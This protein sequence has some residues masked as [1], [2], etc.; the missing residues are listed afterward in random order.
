MVACRVNERLG[1]HM[2]MDE[3]I[4][5][6]AEGDELVSNT[7]F[8]D[9]DLAYDVA[10]GATFDGV[11][12]RSCEF[13]GVDWSGSTF[14]DVVFRGCRFIR[15]NM[16][17]CWLNRC[18][19]VDCSAPG[20]NLLRARL[21]SVSFTLCDLSYANL[22]EGS[23][24][25]MAARDTRLTEAALQGAKLG[26]LRLDGCDLTRIDVFK[27][28]LSGVDVSCCIVRGSCRLGRTTMTLRGLTVNAEQALALS[29]LLGIQLADE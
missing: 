27:T 12:F 11:V 1:S 9:L 15:C 13:D 18:D 24:G 3:L 10:N 14:R 20:L 25:P 7:A 4:D 17:G 23:I 16:E 26:Q 8:E 29:G 21:S 28:P 5:L 19:F 2:G 6:F 22:S